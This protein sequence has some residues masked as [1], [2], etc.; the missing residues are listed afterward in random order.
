MR[1]RRKALNPLSLLVLALGLPQ[2][3]SAATITVTTTADSGPG[4][5]RQAILDSNAS[6]GTLDTIEFVIPGAGVHTIVPASALPT[7]TDPVVIDGSTQPGF[8]GAPLIEL[9]GTSAGGFTHGL[10]I[11]A[12]G[13]TVRAL[14]INRFGGSGIICFT[15]GGNT[16]VGNYI[17]TNPAGT[18]ALANGNGVYLFAPSNGNTVGGTTPEDR[19]LISGNGTG[20]VLNSEDNAVLGNRIGTDVSGLAAVP[21]GTG[22][23]DGTGGNTIGGPLTLPASG[24]CDDTC[25]L[26]SGNTGHG[27]NL[28]QAGNSSTVQ[29]NFVGTDVTGLAPLGNGNY[30]IVIF[31]GNGHFIASNVV[32]GNFVGVGM[33]AGPAVV[34]QG[35]FIGTD[36][37]GLAAIPNEFG[38]VGTFNGG[39]GAQIGG[40]AGA[41]G[42]PCVFPCNL[43]S[44]NSGFGIVLGTGGSSIGQDHDVVQGNCIGTKIDCA[45]PLPNGTDGIQI[46]LQASDETIGG[47]APGEGNVIAF[48]DNGINMN[49]GVRNAIRGNSIFS[50]DGLGIDLGSNG[51]TPN[52]PGDPDTGANL[53]QNFP[54]VTSV[55]PALTSGPQGASTR[56]RGFIRGAAATQ[57]ELDF[58]SNDAC[59]DR[60]Q[61]FLEGHRYLGS[62]SVTTDGAG[63]AAIDVTLPVDVAANDPVSATATDPLGNT[64]EF[65][66]RL[67]LFVFPTSGAPA[68]GTNLSITGTDFQAGATVTIGGIAAGNVV[69]NN[70]NSINAT[71]PLLPAGTVNDL[72]VSNPDGSEG[73]LPK[74][75]VADFLDVA[76]SN[77]F[78]SYVTTLVRNAIT[79]GIGGG[80]YGVNDDT[81]RQQ[82]AVFLLKGKFGLCYTPPPCTGVFNDVPC[83]SSFAPWIEALADLGITGGCGGGNYCPQNPVRRDQMAAF[84]LKTKYGSGYAP[85]PC[86]GVFPD[87][88]CPSQFADWIEELA[89]EQITGGCGGNNYCP[90][91]P[92]TRGQMAVFIVKAFNLQ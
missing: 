60:P 53:L 48:N 10:N 91:N 26:V 64:S 81:L 13:S 55:E 51:V 43:I 44:G 6:A 42:T 54:I 5:L 20:V 73:T 7:I 14:A 11:T 8:A 21:N 9:D 84:L 74:A 49:D 2:G 29:G 85:P 28:S 88:A 32:S 36:A 50:N 27:I 62:S 4:S 89:L 92:N 25:N 56:I 63:F 17:G 82:M 71:S 57:L 61:E 87:V 12:G 65:S 67:P 79:V 22:I 58:F 23:Q 70:S 15:V 77:T 18:A 19:N 45:S 47:T 76:F 86:T 69:F 72:T 40:A 33:N 37:A 35:N 83:S 39:D 68:G 78:Y 1:P 59:A 30:G 75:W 31:N 52:D 34:I 3:I 90:T 16:I 66:Q 38:G 80:L 41:A 46:G 24:P